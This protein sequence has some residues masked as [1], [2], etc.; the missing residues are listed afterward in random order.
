MGFPKS[1]SILRAAL[2]WDLSQAAVNT[3]STLDILEGTACLIIVF[4]SGNR[5]AVFLLWCLQHLIPHSSSL[6]LLSAE[7]FHS[8]IFIC[9]SQLLLHS[10]FFFNSFLIMPLRSCYQCSWWTQL[11]LAMGASESQLEL[12]LSV[13]SSFWHHLTEAI[14]AV[15]PLSKPCCI[16]HTTPIHPCY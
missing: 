2:A 1:Y 12:A 6:T 7:F 10:G 4:A 3:C 14:P 9:L 11:W 15:L 13:G 16:N 8:H 5:A